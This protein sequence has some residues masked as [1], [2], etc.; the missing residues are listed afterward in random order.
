MIYALPT[1][2]ATAQS[3]DGTM[4]PCLVI[5][6]QQK[7][8]RATFKL[9]SLDFYAPQ[10][11][12]AYTVY[13]NPVISGTPALTFT[14]FPDTRSMVEYCY[15]GTP[16]NYTYTNGIPIRSGFVSKNA[17]FVDQ[18]TTQELITA[19]SFC[20]DIQGNPDTLMIACSEYSNTPVY[21]TARWLEIV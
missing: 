1:S 15:T 5:R 3:I 8:C 10:G 14:P 17:S 9:I 11:D 6:L 19:H 16:T 18:I 21:I 20:S 12:I 4:R 2:L 7:Y 13:K